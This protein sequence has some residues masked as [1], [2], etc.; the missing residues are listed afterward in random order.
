MATSV[1]VKGLPLNG[2]AIYARLFTNFYGRMEYVDFTYSAAAPAVLL[3]P[4]PGSTLLGNS[5]TF[6]WSA[7]AGAT[8]YGLWL[9]TLGVGSNNVRTSGA[10]TSTLAT[11]GALP[12]NGQT[13][14]ARMIT[15]F[16]GIFVSTDSTYTAATFSSAKLTSPAPGSTLTGSNASFTW[17]TGTGAN[18]YQIL[19]GST[20]VGSRN[21]YD[22]GSTT[23]NSIAISGLPTNGKP[24]YVRLYTTFNGSSQYSDSTCTAVAQTP[25]TLASPKPGSTIYSGVVFTWTAGQGVTS[26]QLLLGTAGAGSSDLY[27]SGS[28]TATT[29]PVSGLPAKGATVYARLLSQIAGAWQS[30]DYTYTEANAPPALT[31]P[32]PGSILGKSNVT[33]TWSA[34]AGYTNYQLWLGTSGP[35]S[36]G[37]FSSGSTTANSVT[38]PKLP[39]NGAKIYARLFYGNGAIWNYT[40]YTFTAQ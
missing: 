3:L 12:T 1:T 24:L 8:L 7:A 9:G 13:I 34:A 40:D 20:G 16:N 31:A 4:A 10:T 35:G 26:Y 39:A 33:F 23:A 21:I 36:S 5:A 37:L 14:Y 18:A 11:L 6:T 29:A 38:V 28:T 19:I 27:N 25:A 17:T 32:A 30:V 15:D 2:E 22:S